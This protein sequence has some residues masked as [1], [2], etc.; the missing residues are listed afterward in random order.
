MY[1]FDSVQIARPVELPVARRMSV[2]P[3]IHGL[4]Y[5]PIVKTDQTLSWLIESPI[6]GSFPIGALANLDPDLKSTKNVSVSDREV[7]DDLDEV[8]PE[9]TRLST[10]I[11]PVSSGLDQ[12]ADFWWKT[13]GTVLGLMMQKAGYSVESLQK[14]LSFF[15]RSVAPA[16]GRSPGADGKPQNWTSFMTDDFTPIE[17]SWCWKAGKALPVVRYAVEPIART[18]GTGHEPLNFRATKELIRKSHSYCSDIELD[19]LRQCVSELLVQTET[20]ETSADGDDSSQ[21]FLAWDLQE[22]GASLKAYFLPNLRTKQTGQSKLKLMQSCMD[23]LCVQQPTM[24]DAFSAFSDYVRARVGEDALTVEIAAIDCVESSASRVKVYA[25]CR[26]TAFDSVRDVMTMSGL[27][28]S[29][30]M[31]TAIASLKELWAL[32]LGLPADFDPSAPLPHSQHRTAGILYYFEFKPGAKLPSVKVYIPVKHY[33]INDLEVAKGLSKFLAGR[34]NR[35][36]DCGY[37]E[38]MQQIFDHRELQAGSGLQTYVTAAI[39]GSALTVTAY[40]NPEIYK[41]RRFARK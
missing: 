7:S 6:A 3:S 4:S 8:E 16:M 35:F 25:R 13:T 9:E 31:R 30:N 38:A 1:D 17:L 20:P 39:A 27:L 28:D 41:Y 12:D 18:A 21:I 11:T 22:H 40:V 37:V 34:G 29:E 32:V 15:R 24:A 36:A 26:Q 10:S 14:H 33:G 23:K 5:S 2:D 19:W